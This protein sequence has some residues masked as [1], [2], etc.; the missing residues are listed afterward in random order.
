VYTQES[1]NNVDRRALQDQLGQG[2]AWLRG[3][4]ICGNNKPGRKLT[5]CRR[6]VR[7]K[8]KADA[9]LAKLSGIKRGSLIAGP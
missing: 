4:H 9:N 1:K 8:E 5:I 3:G 2:T 6:M 7:G